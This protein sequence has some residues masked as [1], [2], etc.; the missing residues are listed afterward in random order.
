MWLIRAW[1]YIHAEFD[2]Y[3]AKPKPNGY[4]SIHTVIVS[5]ENINVEIQI[6]TYQMHEESELGVAA[7]WQYKE[8]GGK[9]SSYAEKINWL[10]HIMD[11]QKEVSTPQDNL[12]HKIF[13]DRVYVF[14]PNGDVFDLEAGATPLDF[15]YHVHTELGH[16][17]RGA[18]VNDMI[19]PL[20]HPLR[21]GDQVAII[22]G[23]ESQSQPRLG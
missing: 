19:V 4:R 15:A 17:C 11:W 8:A 1:R 16:R 23:K 9:P 3:I 22:A 14:T 5:P 21:T 10:R 2:D 12:Y 13:E 7:H 18:K 20:T 6:R